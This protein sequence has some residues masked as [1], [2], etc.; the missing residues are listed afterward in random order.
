MASALLTEQ[1]GLVLSGRLH[2]SQQ[3]VMCAP[4]FCRCGAHRAHLFFTTMCVPLIL[5]HVS[6]VSPAMEVSR[7][8]IHH[9]FGSSLNNLRERF[10]AYLVRR[11]WQTQRLEGHAVHLAV[12]IS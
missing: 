10:P 6:V 8:T 5:R 3:L 11:Q 9:F 2:E 12:R 7:R 4:F 1:L